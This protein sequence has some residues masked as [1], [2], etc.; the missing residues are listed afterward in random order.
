MNRAI[1]NRIHAAISADHLRRL[2]VIYVRQSTLE[3]VRDNTGSATYQKNLTAVAQSYGWPDSRI[4]IIDDDLGKSGCSTEGRTGWQRLQEM[5]DA[6]QVGAVFAANMSRLSRRLSDFELFRLR[7]AY[8]NTILYIDGRF[9]NPADSNDAAVS[10]IT[11]MVAQFEN[12]KRAELM[13]QGRLAKAKRGEV[14]TRLPLGWIKRFDGQYDYDLAVKDTIAMIINTFRQTR[15]LHRTVKQLAQA[16]ITLPPRCVRSPGLNRNVGRPFP[17][18]KITL[19]RVKAIL[20]H[21]AYAGTY[22]WTAPITA[23]R[24][25]RIGGRDRCR[26]RLHH[27]AR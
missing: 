13:M 1:T 17:G 26:H 8:H 19:E 15:S 18:R 6:D 4:V 5:I 16:R 21:P 14:M 3:Q 27:E 9:L 2:A 7:A 24:R 10:Q 22:I 12:R 20:V 25:R 23:R 11:A